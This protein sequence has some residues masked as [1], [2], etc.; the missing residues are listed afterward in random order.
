MVAGAKE[1]K[2]IGRHVA[3]TAE[4]RKCTLAVEGGRRLK[5]AGHLENL[6][7]DGRITLEPTL[8]M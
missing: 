8:N 6:G 3:S 5:D 1:K 4:R 2:E 7:V